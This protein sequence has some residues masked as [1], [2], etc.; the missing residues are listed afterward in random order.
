M[1]SP[2]HSL[3]GGWQG[4][5]VYVDDPCHSPPVRFEATWTM[6][7]DG[8]RFTGPVL[9]DGPLGQS[10][11]DGMQ[12]GRQVAFTKVYVDQSS[13][14]THPIA[15][16]GTLSEDGMTVTGTWRLSTLSGTWDARRIIPTP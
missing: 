6:Q 8:G 9:D 13:S 15:Y 1:N 3:A 11:T 5:Y 4:T 7:G 12:T 10:E 16:E 14:Y 2:E